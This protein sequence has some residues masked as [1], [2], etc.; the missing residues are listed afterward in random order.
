M[1]KKE[2]PI[3]YNSEEVLKDLLKNPMDSML[4][5]KY[6]VL[7]SLERLQIKLTHEVQKISKH[8]FGLIN[9]E[10]KTILIT[11]SRT[12]GTCVTTSYNIYVEEEFECVSHFDVIIYHDEKRMCLYTDYENSV[13]YEGLVKQVTEK[14]YVNEVVE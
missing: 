1:R 13:K 11:F 2:E 9:E 5:N 3:S 6:T 4:S 14:Y 7:C 8:H 12:W 10:G